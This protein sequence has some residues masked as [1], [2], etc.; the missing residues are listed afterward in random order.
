[1]CCGKSTRAYELA[2]AGFTRTAYLPNALQ[3][4]R[5]RAPTQRGGSHYREVDQRKLQQA[6]RHQRPLTPRIRA[7]PGLSSVTR[8][9]IQQSPQERFYLMRFVKNFIREEDGQDVVEYA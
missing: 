2:N 9:S 1:M 3:V 4:G 5:R 6:T 8:G 7:L